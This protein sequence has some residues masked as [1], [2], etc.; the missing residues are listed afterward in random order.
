M[1]PSTM[2]GVYRAYPTIED[3][4]AEVPDIDRRLS[5][6]VDFGVWWARPGVE[7]PRY[8]V[9]W[10]E[11][12]G[13]LYSIAQ[14][15]GRKTAGPVELLAHIEQR[16]ALEE[17]L[18]GWAEHC[19]PGGLEWLWE[20]VGLDAR[21]FYCRRCATRSI[22]RVL[23]DVA[24]PRA[25]CGGNHAS[26]WRDARNYYCVRCEQTGRTTIVYGEPTE[27][28]EFGHRAWQST[29]E[30]LWVRRSITTGITG[31]RPTA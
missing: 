14:T 26:D 29:D 22:V 6:E 28:C 4:Y 1:T 11:N 2:T 18:D 10:V 30:S 3:F 23:A 24:T 8:R 17:L 5:G 27:P 7:M 15:G 9:S 31:E 19:G 16:K 21:R 12:T 25:H 13:E 20:R